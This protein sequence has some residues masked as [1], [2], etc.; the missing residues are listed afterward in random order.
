VAWLASRQWGVI[1]LSQL[2]D[3]GITSA[4]VTRWVETGRLVRIHPGVYAVGHTSLPTEGH[5]AAAV[6]YAGR[7]SGLSGA[8]GAYWWG[9]AHELPR[10]FDVVSPK[11]KVWLPEVRVHRATRIELVHHN[12]LPVTTVARTVV[13]LAATA[14]LKVVRRA[15]SKADY[16]NLL[17][18]RAVEAELG[19]GVKGA[20]KVRIALERHTVALARSRSELERALVT[21]CERHHIPLPLINIKFQG[22]TVDAVWLDQ[23]VAVEVDGYG[24]HR[25]PAQLEEDHARDMALRAA[26]F[27]VL[28]YT[29][30]QLTREPEL[31]AADLQ[32]ALAARAA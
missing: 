6:L 3:C 31:V 25:S 26:G 14:P 23:K 11:R 5:L 18:V 10:R 16:E 27:I 20:N 15:L 32:R 21:F 28:R 1:A 29:W 24:G 22:W 8:T 30:K 7:D 13:D 12:R 17:D 19:R 9:I 2:L 4:T